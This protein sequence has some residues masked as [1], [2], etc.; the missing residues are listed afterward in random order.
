M[1]G[2]RKQTEFDNLQ[3]GSA[4]PPTTWDDDLESEVKDGP[5]EPMTAKNPSA[6][7]LLEPTRLSLSTLLADDEDDPA[8][9]SGSIAALTEDPLLSRRIVSSASSSNM[10]GISNQYR[11]SPLTASSSSN[12]L[13]SNHN[14]PNLPPGLEKQEQTV[15]PENVEW[16]YTD[17]SGQVQGEMRSSTALGCL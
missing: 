16:I 10:N 1:N 2:S 12:S 9:L 8:L 11:A 17:P 7:N 5:L 15:L 4:S 14:V 6:D 13:H 3:N